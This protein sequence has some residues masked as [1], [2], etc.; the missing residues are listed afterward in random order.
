MDTVLK[1]I[2][3]ILGNNFKNEIVKFILIG[4][5]T[6]DIKMDNSDYDIIIV[7]NS[8]VDSYDFIKHAT[9]YVSQI[10]FENNSKIEIYP[11]KKQNLNNSSSQFINNVILNG[12]EF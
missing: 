7:T 6:R 1:S 3:T 4:S 10:S 8:F 12:I 9:R 2:K 11:I 5:R